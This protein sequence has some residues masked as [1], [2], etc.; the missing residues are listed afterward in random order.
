MVMMN[1]K[2]QKTELDILKIKPQ[3]NLSTMLN[4]LPEILSTIKLK[5]L[6]IN[7]SCSSSVTTSL[8][9]FTDYKL[10]PFSCL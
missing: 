8:F 5:I 10:S 2:R 7:A 4:L 6:S 9:I 1:L 3:S